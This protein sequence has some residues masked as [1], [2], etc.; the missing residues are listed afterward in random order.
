MFSDTHVEKY[1]LPYAVPNFEQPTTLAFCNVYILGGTTDVTSTP[2]RK[3]DA[4]YSLIASDNTS[5]DREGQ[6]KRHKY[7]ALTTSSTKLLLWPIVPLYSLGKNLILLYL[8]VNFIT[9]IKQS[10]C[11]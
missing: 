9:I 10:I 1:S 7:P 6:K 8:L 2:L 11:L 5:E 4:V 3:I